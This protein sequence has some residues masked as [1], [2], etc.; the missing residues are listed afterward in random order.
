MKEPQHHTSGSDGYLAPRAPIARLCPSFPNVIRFP[1]A[2]TVARGGG[3][4]V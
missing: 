2:P 1:R 4:V 3:P